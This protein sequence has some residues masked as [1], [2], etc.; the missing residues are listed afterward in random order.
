ML[1]A[2]NAVPRPISPKPSTRD[3][4]EFT[5]K[6]ESDDGIS[7]KFKIT[8]ALI[9]NEYKAGVPRG[10][11]R[12]LR[13]PLLRLKSLLFNDETEEHFPRP[14][15]FSSTE[16][17][18]EELVLTPL[19]MKERKLKSDITATLQSFATK[20]GSDKKVIRFDKCRNADD[21]H[22]LLKDLIS[23]DVKLSCI[24]VKLPTFELSW[25]NQKRF[26][27]IAAKFPEIMQPR[28]FEY[29]KD[30]KGQPRSA[31]G[32]D[33]KI[34]NVVDTDN[35]PEGRWKLDRQ[36]DRWRLDPNFRGIEITHR[37]L[38]DFIEAPNKCETTLESLSD[39]LHNNRLCLH[40]IEDDNGT[41]SSDAKL[42]IMK[43][44]T[45]VWK[46]DLNAITQNGGQNVKLSARLDRVPVFRIQVGVS[47]GIDDVNDS[48]V[49][50]MM[51]FKPILEREI[52]MSVAKQLFVPPACITLY[53]AVVDEEDFDSDESVDDDEKS[54][55]ELVKPVYCRYDKPNLA[56][57]T[58]K[59]YTA[60]I[61]EIC[62]DPKYIELITTLAEARSVLKRIIDEHSTDEIV[63]GYGGDCI[64]REGSLSA[65]TVAVARDNFEFTIPGDSWLHSFPPMVYVFDLQLIGN[66]D[67][68]MS[69]EGNSPNCKDD[70]PSTR[71]LSF[72][73]DPALSKRVPSFRDIFESKRMT[74]LMYD[75]RGFADLLHHQF[76]IYIQNVYDVQV[77]H[78]L[79]FRRTNGFL[80]G[81]SKAVSKLCSRHPYETSISTFEPRD[82][83]L[84][85]NWPLYA[86][87][88]WIAH[89]EQEE[90]EDFQ[91]VP[92]YYVCRNLW[93]E[94]SSILL[95][96]VKHKSVDV[97]YCEHRWSF[98]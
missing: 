90:D 52:R 94:E 39:I 68:L 81:I 93:K 67:E 5:L 71:V 59:E 6:F 62:Y 74:K 12:R 31:M 87:D 17:N 48:F 96:A 1:R 32:R 79:K 38:V 46:Y 80:C 85:V 45:A 24:F 2:I 16:L 3:S 33:V 42:Q 72:F 84:E 44:D 98:G 58:E 49:V 26:K 35:F 83:S 63:V 37:A 41:G 61:K 13:D 43:P 47:G 19:R 28:R 21:L 56:D 30:S 18:V 70:A 10:R 22:A 65:I 20:E 75:C 54:S 60:H 14:E 76:D 69:T 95:S 91:D 73:K 9:E 55:A 40:I 15:C 82:P 64:C 77:L 53:P 97:T 34:R 51:S 29:Y 89:Y 66:V 86:L 27:D 4:T 57:V 11:R 7:P 78:T 23:D 36:K 88:E 50:D 25:Q 92:K 8:F